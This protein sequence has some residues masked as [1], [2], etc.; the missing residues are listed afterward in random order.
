MLKKYVGPAGSI[1]I[2]WQRCVQEAKL[3]KRSTITEASRN[4]QFL[5]EAFKC[6][7]T[8]EREIETGRDGQT[9]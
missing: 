6:V 1:N 4:V 3:C 8:I 5:L 9:L 7:Q 2:P